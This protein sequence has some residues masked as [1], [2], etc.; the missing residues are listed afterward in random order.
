LVNPVVLVQD[1]A[2]GL[3]ADPILNSSSGVAPTTM[4]H[5]SVGNAITIEWT[6]RIGSNGITGSGNPSSTVTFQLLRGATVLDTITMGY[7]FYTAEAGF[8]SWVANPGEVNTVVDTPGVGTFSYTLTMT[9]DSSDTI[10]TSTG[11]ITSREEQ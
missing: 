11:S 5:M 9:E 6:Y 10:K 4:N 8:W 1:G 2:D 3:G 7:T